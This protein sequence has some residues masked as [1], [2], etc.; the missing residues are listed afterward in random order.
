M[1]RLEFSRKV[2]RAIIERANGRCEACKAAMKRGEGEVD[3]IRPDALGG[4]PTA[5]NG[6]LICEV[7][8]KSKTAADVRQ[9]RKAD[10][11]RDKSSGAIRPK[12]SIPSPPKQPKPAS[13]TSLPPRNLFRSAS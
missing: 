4:A 1:A 13:K 6:R 3:H 11:Q 9:I 12:G 5:A 2:R 8:H 7:C 10:R